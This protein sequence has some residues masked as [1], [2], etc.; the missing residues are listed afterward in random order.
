MISSGGKSRSESTGPSPGACR[1]VLPADPFG[2]DPFGEDLAGEPLGE[3]TPRGLLR[4]P[5]LGR[6]HGAGHAVQVPPHDPGGRPR[7]VTPGGPHHL[8]VPS[9]ERVPSPGRAPSPRGLPGELRYHPREHRGSSMI[10]LG[11]AHITVVTHQYGEVRPPAH[12]GDDVG[13]DGAEQGEVGGG[14]GGPGHVRRHGPRNR[15]PR[16]MNRHPGA[17]GGPP[18][19]L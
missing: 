16:A 14:D 18:G 10:A 5:G 12:V 13:Q 11:N 9:P 8:G 3:G 1:S 2:E 17:G 19:D 15:V 7:H 6:G 4:H